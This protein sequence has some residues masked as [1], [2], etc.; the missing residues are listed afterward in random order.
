MKT[1]LLHHER[2]LTASLSRC[3]Q[4][5]GEP[6][7]VD[8]KMGFSTRMKPKERRLKLRETLFSRSPLLTSLLPSSRLNDSDLFL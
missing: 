1:T 4:I 2:H 6:M 5:T 7:Q 3:I 8:G